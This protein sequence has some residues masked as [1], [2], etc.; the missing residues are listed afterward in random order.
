MTMKLPFSISFAITADLA[1]KAAEA[2]FGPHRF[3]LVPSPIGQFGALVALGIV[4]HQIVTYLQE[5]AWYRRRRRRSRDAKERPQARNRMKI[6][7]VNPAEG[8]LDDR[9][10]HRVVGRV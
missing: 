4:L 8:P 3:T 7:D 6:D 9:P 1:L 5:L 10:Q 2:V